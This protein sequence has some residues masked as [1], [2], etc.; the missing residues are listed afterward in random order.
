[1]TLI[2]RVQIEYTSMWLR[3]LIVF[4]ATWWFW[5]RS[6]HMEVCPKCIT[7]RHSC[8]NWGREVSTSTNDEQMF[9]ASNNR[10]SFAYT[11]R[12]PLPLVPPTLTYVR[13]HIHT[14][15]FSLVFYNPIII[16]RY[17]NNKCTKLLAWYNEDLKSIFKTMVH[18]LGDHWRPS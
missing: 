9:Y 11:S 18:V 7:S 6:M 2:L 4:C 15:W 13:S 1:M 3:G 16:L 8:L 17:G 12:E 10:I 5:R 14:V